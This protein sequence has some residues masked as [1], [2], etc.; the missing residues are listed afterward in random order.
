MMG[1][2]KLS[3]FAEMQGVE[4]FC[5]AAYEVHVSKKFLRNAAVGMKCEFL[6]API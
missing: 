1:A 3:E 5:R 4:N 6:E 2:S